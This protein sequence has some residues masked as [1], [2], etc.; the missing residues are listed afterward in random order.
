[1]TRCQEPLCPKCGPS[2]L[3]IFKQLFSILPSNLFSKP[4]A[5]PGPVESQWVRVALNETDKELST[6]DAEMARSKWALKKLQCRHDALIEHR[7]LL[8]SFLLAKLVRRLSPELLSEIFMHCL[9]QNNYELTS[10]RR[11][12]A[13]LLFGQVCSYW[14]KVSLSTPGLWSSLCLNLCTPRNPDIIADAVSTWLS[15]SGQLPL[16][17]SLY[18]REEAP[19]PLAYSAIRAIMPYSQRWESLDLFLPKS[20]LR[21]LFSIPG[22][23]PRLRRL[24]IQTHHGAQEDESS[25]I[26]APRLAVVRLEYPSHHMVDLPW[27]QITH[28]HV[29]QY[30]LRSCLRIIASAPSLRVCNID[31]Q[32]RREGGGDVGEE[33]DNDNHDNSSFSTDSSPLPMTPVGSNMLALSFCKTESTE[34]TNLFSNLTLPELS[35]LYVFDMLGSWPLAEFASL[36]SRSQFRLKKLVLQCDVGHDF[37]GLVTSGEFQELKH[38]DLFLDNVEDKVGSAKHD[39][40]RRLTYRPTRSTTLAGR[41]Q[42]SEERSLLVPSILMPKLEVIS[43]DHVPVK[44]SRA[45]VDLVESRWRLKP[46]VNDVSRLQYVSL[47]SGKRFDTTLIERLG[48]FV[49]EGLSMKAIIEECV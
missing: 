48:E 41:G 6:V 8:V 16:S 36:A 35:D 7:E 11:D 29:T 25:V 3:P 2:I 19:T 15:R 47:K 39:F 43:F 14:R 17:L 22:P 5:T 32:V 44:C 21:S 42:P 45:L 13:P 1:M 12:A 46:L 49:K 31:S 33:E 27:H 9:P 20:L 28:L 23:L 38:L 30:D 18:F 40:I 34:I 37:Y 4:T 24:G 10:L 26:L